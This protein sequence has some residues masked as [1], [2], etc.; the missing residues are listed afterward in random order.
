MAAELWFR[1][2]EVTASPARPRCIRFAASGNMI[3]ALALWMLCAFPQAV[4]AKDPACRDIQ[5]SSARLACYDLASPPKL[6]Q[7]AVTDSDPS[8]P[9]Y[10][11]PFVEED[12]KTTAKLKGICRGC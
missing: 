6:Q 4:H 11:D 2:E 5:S 8:R 9:A 1:Q 10:R 3:G 12:A 7:P